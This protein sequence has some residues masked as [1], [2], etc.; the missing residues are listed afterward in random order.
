MAAYS[1]SSHLLVVD[2][3]ER[4]RTL[5]QRY[6]VRNGY[7]CSGARDAVHALRLLERLWIDLVIMDVMMPGQSGI[8]L[9]EK[10]RRT[11]D[12]PIIVLSAKTDLEDRI[13]GLRAGADDYVQKPYEPEELLLRIEAVLRRSPQGDPADIPQVITMGE[14]EFSPV[15][16]E[17]CRGDSI[18]HL[19]D[20]EQQLLRRLAQTPNRAVPRS[21]F[22]SESDGA[23]GT[24]KDRAIDVRVSRLRQKFEA[25][26]RRP[27]YLLTV[28]SEGYMLVPD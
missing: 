26:P 12:V 23:A 6:L 17:L 2:D 16:G 19:T 8:E 28:R 21:E 24:V 13:D 27:R 5:L 14:F 10:L 20:F 25:I 11:S 22:M 9:T 7:W 18:I 1:N 4:L 15:R 3:D